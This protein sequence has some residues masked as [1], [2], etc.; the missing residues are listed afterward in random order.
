MTHDFNFINI[1][2]NEV[3]FSLK[4]NEITNVNDKDIA[5]I[6]VYSFLF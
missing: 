4:L 5:F 2:E 3:R 1:D 6:F